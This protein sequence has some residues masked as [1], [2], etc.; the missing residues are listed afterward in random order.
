MT[1]KELNLS[2]FGRWFNDDHLAGLK[3]I[4]FA[5]V[6]RGDFEVEEYEYRQG[7]E[8]LDVLLDDQQ[9]AALQEIEALFLK[10]ILPAAKCGFAAG[11]FSGFQRYFRKSEDVIHSLDKAMEDLPRDERRKQ[12]VNVLL[13]ELL[14]RVPD[15]A[16]E[17]I[18]SVEC[19]W[20]QR[21]HYAFIYEFYLGFRCALAVIDRIS[22]LETREM[23]SEKLLLEFEIGLIND[24]D[25]MERKSIVQEFL[26]K[27][28]GVD[29]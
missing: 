4:Y 27:R 20:E 13:E 18:T 22:P 28:F 14:E 24:V 23:F 26:E 11:L 2:S 16:E 21:I 25:R 29:L 8:N 1:A 7:K 3:E 6:K 19:A 9:K 10:E 17:H 15:G 5:R 12:T